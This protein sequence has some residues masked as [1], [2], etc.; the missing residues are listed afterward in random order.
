MSK[1]FLFMFHEFWNFHVSWHKI[2][3]FRESAENLRKLRHSRSLIIK[4]N[5]KCHEAKIEESEESAEFGKKSGLKVS[6]SIF[7]IFL[8]WPEFETKLNMKLI[9]RKKQ[10]GKVNN[11]SFDSLPAKFTAP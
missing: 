6:K 1:Y 4:Q 10:F 9:E 11:L 2:E 5:K 3:R 8:F 7:E